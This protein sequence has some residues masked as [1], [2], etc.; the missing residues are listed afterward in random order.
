MYRYAGEGRHQKLSQLGSA[1]LPLNH[2]L[3]KGGYQFNY[4]CGG[5]SRGI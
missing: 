5:L 4:L 3:A 1:E 2:Q